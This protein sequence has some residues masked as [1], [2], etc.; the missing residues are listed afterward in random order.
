[1][2]HFYF[3]LHLTLAKFG[4]T[5]VHMSKRVMDIYLT[6]LPEVA[7][8]MAKSYIQQGWIIERLETRNFEFFKHIDATWE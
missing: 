5:P 4:E 1:M 2:P 7:Y 6:I 8:N 3:E